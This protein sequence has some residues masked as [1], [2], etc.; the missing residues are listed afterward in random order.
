MSHILGGYTFP[1]LPPDNAWSGIKKVKSRVDVST[2]SSNVTLNWGVH[3]KGSLVSYEYPLM[4]E[5]FFQSL[6]NK[7]ELDQE[8]NYDPKDGHIYSVKIV[9]FTGQ[10]YK[11]GSYRSNVVLNLKILEQLT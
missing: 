6:K 5:N 8:F 7:Y 1:Y 11:K 9:H 4:E 2:Y 3:I 10:V